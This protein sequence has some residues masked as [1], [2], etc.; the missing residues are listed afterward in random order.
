MYRRYLC[1]RVQILFFGQILCISKA[2]TPRNDGHLQKYQDYFT[3]IL[4][5]TFFINVCFI[6]VDI[7]PKSILSYF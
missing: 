7:Y 6:T 4:N 1:C 2:F 5:N 3:V